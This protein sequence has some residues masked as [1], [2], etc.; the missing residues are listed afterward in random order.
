MNDRKYDL[1]I[2]HELDQDL[3]NKR[4][5]RNRMTNTLILFVHD[6]HYQEVPS[7]IV[8]PLWGMGD[9]WNPKRR[10]KLSMSVD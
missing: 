7:H 1:R 4:F 3:I 10:R 9:K 5:I 6:A 8:G 2:Y